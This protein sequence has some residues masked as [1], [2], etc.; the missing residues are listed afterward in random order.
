MTNTAM[1][2]SP[3]EDITGVSGGVRGIREQQ[4]E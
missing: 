3:T 2:N 1:L 4:G